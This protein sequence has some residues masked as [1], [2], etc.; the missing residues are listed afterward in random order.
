MVWETTIDGTTGRTYWYDRATG[1]TTWKCPPNFDQQ[2]KELEIQRK[3]DDKEASLE[4]ARV[5]K[6][7]A[8]ATRKKQEA[9]QPALTL[10][11]TARC[12]K[13]GRTYWYKKKTKKVKTTTTTQ[14]R[15]CRWQ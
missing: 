3:A 2:Q 5:A 15:R 4:R 6:I 14:H 12:S 7:V 10:W 13:T 11:K 9:L 8:R 1:V